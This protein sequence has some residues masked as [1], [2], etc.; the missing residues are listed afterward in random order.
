[1]GQ[2]TIYV[3][4]EHEPLWERAKALA[5]TDSLSN[6]IAEGLRT[7]IQERERT[8]ALESLVA[9]YWN[10][11]VLVTKKLSGIRLHGSPDFQGKFSSSS[12]QIVLTRR[13]HYVVW[14]KG[15]ENDEGFWWVATSLDDEILR[16]N[17]PQEA[18]AAAGQLLAV[19][20]EWIP[21][22]DL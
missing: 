17:V 9:E 6:I 11:G 14:R 5:G 12:W 3:K 18:R 15:S 22:L 20:P 7:F 4:E 2:R 1:M 8:L 10:A 21:E 13:G 19:H 16:R